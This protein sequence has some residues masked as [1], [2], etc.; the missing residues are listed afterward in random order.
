MKKRVF[1]TL[2]CAG[3]ILATVWAQ[4]FPQTPKRETLSEAIQF[5]KHKVAAADAQ[6]RRDAGESARSQR[7]SKTS[8][9]RTS[10]QQGQADTTQQSQPEKPKQ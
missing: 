5:E 2:L 9:A 8:K 6:A 3:A 1:R 7:A 10:R 4:E